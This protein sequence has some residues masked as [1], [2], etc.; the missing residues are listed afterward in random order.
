MSSGPKEELHKLEQV[1]DEGESAET[2][3]ILF[4]EVWVVCAIAAIV[5]GALT[6]LGYRLAT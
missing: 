1:A 4:G 6:Y 2:P 5:L 3:L